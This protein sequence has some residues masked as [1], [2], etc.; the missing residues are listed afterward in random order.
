MREAA[1][2]SLASVLIAGSCAAEDAVDGVSGFLIEENAES[3]A[4]K[5]AELCQKPEVIRAVGEGALR[6]LYI[7]WDDAV[8]N[9][10][11]RYETVIEKHRAGMYPKHTGLSEDL[12]HTIAQGMEGYNR[13]RDMQKAAMRELTESYR[14]LRDE[15]LAEGQRRMDD[16]QEGQSRLSAELE[17]RQQQLRAKLDELARYID[18]FM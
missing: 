5:L 9:A 10:C 12:I 2:C 6:E 18:R 17:A 15:L 16:L 7:S 3:M 8:A 1:A 11:R 14:H 13:S 4:A